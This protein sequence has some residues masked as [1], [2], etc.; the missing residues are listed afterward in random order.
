M[1][2][3][4][5]SERFDGTGVIHQAGAV[6]AG[7]V[8]AMRARLCEAVDALDG[9]DEDAGARRPRLGSEHAMN[10]VVQDPIFDGLAAH[11]ARTV[12]AIFGANRWY[13]ATGAWRGV[14]LPNLPGAAGAWQVPHQHWHFDEAPSIRARPW[15]L[16][17]F[18]FLD[19]VVAG[20]GTTLVMTGSARRLRAHAA[21]LA[22]DRDL[23]LEESTTGLARVEPWV[24]ELLDPDY[25][26][27]RRRRFLDEGCVSRDVPLRIVELVGEPGDVVFM[28]PRSL[29]A[30]SA[31][32][33]AHARLVVKMHVLAVR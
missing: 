7:E 9:L 33:S 1:G 32:A 23:T 18:V 24:R 22:P 31:N 13:P 30:P 21:E 6:P 25:R 28:D 17:A 4:A 11:L 8:R 10:A 29:H 2:S 15:S 12:D 3:P 19:R 20:G 5:P 27:D 16:G 26:P 14:A